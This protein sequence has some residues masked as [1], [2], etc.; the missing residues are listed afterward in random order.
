MQVVDRVRTELARFRARIESDVL[1]AA[2]TSD[3]LTQLREAC[4]HELPDELVSYLKLPGLF[5]AAP[6]VYVFDACDFGLCAPS[7]LIDDAVNLR[8][9]AKEYNWDLPRCCSLYLVNNRFLAFNFDSKQLICI[10]GS[11]GEV[12]ELNGGLEELLGQY[13]DGLEA[14][15]G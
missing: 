9:A 3:E 8:N 11:D 1:P 13:A 12:T 6:E 2:F 10:D 4:G 15:N 5:D 14:Q 7:T